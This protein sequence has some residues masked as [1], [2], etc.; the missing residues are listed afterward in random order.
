[1]LL[2]TYKSA[3]DLPEQ[4]DNLATGNPYMSRDFLA[5]IE[6]TEHDYT[7]EYYLFFDGDAADSCFVAFVNTRFDIAMFTQ[8]HIFKRVTMIYLPMSVT[9]PSL[10]PGRL[11]PQVLDTIKR[12][13]GY[14]LVLNMPDE[15]AEGFATGYTCPKCILKLR[16]KSFDDYCNSL[17]SDYRNRLKKVFRRSDMLRIR[18][19]DN[20]KEFD[21]TYYRMYLNVLNNSATKI[22][23]L[24]R[25]YFCGEAF[26]IFAAELEG[27][28]VGFV[29]LLE[30]GGELIFEFVGLDYDYNAKYQ[31]YHR[32]LYEIVRYGISNGFESIDFGQTADDTKLKLGCRYEYLYAW[33]RHSNAVINFLCKKFAPKLAY[34]PFTTNFRVFKEED[35]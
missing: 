9:R 1:M 19:I 18:F 28:P 16:W 14:T 2:K 35:R 12:I 24:S 21:E 22:E 5:F 26:K 8:R 7:P 29:Q 27:R 20:K 32:M 17:R 10:I 11:R 13:K 4:W 33:L 34:T 15:N 23:T 30:N 25:E 6:R 31:V 3:R